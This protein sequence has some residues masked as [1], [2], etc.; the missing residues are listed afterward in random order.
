[1]TAVL[2]V[3]TSSEVNRPDL[4]LGAFGGVVKTSPG[5]PVHAA[6]ERRVVTAVVEGV[7]VRLVAGITV[8]PGAFVLNGA[9]MWISIVVSVFGAEGLCIVVPQ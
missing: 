7:Q 6:S 3:V 1:M 4:H 9:V 8:P 2:G 5:L